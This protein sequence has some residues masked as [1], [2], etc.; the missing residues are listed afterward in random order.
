MKET[1]RKASDVELIRRVKSGDT[2]AFDE[3]MRRYA[4]SIYRLV[5][6]LA[7]NHM[8]AD[9]LSQ[10]TFI[11]AYRA[12]GRYDEQYRFY[13]WLHR[14]AVNLCINHLKRKR[15]VRLVP[16]PGSEIGGE[17]QDIAD[18]KSGA[19]VSEL[20]RDLDRALCKLP[21]DQ[22]AVIVL[23]VK[24]EMS[25]SEISDVLK[26]PVGTVMSRLSR[27]RSRLRRLLKEY[28]PV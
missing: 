13:T 10:E 7:R 26:I 16:L 3:L 19:E 11:R 15:R 25:Y 21:V 1:Y 28:L 22:R 5:Y 14:I 24:E 8:D 2:R 6:S 4:G 23:R 18:P 20:Q 17:W 27:A 9:D 12:I